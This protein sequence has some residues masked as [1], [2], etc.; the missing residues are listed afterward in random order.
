MA[1]F[2]YRK[3]EQT[4]KLIF[5]KAAAKLFPAGRVTLDHSLNNGIYGT[6]TKETPLSDEDIAALKKTMGEIVEKNYPI[7]LVTD[8]CEKLKMSADT[9]AREDVRKLLQNSG[10]I[11]VGCYEVHG[12]YDYL[13]T[14]VKP[15]NYTGDAPLFD[16]DRYNG[17]FILRYPITEE[18]KLLPRI[19]NPKMAK[20]FQETNEWERILGV[21]TIGYL[22]EK[23][24]NRDIGEL[25]RVNEALHHRNIAKIAGNIMEN[26]DIRLVT[27]AGPSS[28]G[29]TTFSKRLYVYLRACGVNPVII[30]LDDYYVGRDNIP[31]DENGK[32]DYETIDAL[33]LRLLNDNLRAL[34]DGEEVLVPQYNFRT[35]TREA[36]GKLLKLPKGGVII[37]EGIHGLNEKMSAAIE[38]RNKYKIYVS[39][40]TELNIDDHNRISTSD[41]RLIRRLVRDSFSRDIHVEETLSMW[42]SVRLGEQKHIFPFQ[43]EADVI[44]N[45][46][47]V[48]ELAVL[49]SF[50]L[51]ELIKVRVGTPS[52]QLAKRLLS[53][54]SCF[55][56]IGVAYVPD[57][58]LLR[59]FVGGSSFIEANYGKYN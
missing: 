35:G 29:K 54:V 18:G 47:L 53:L 13:Y 11:T 36:E 57:D 39:C 7:R 16:V 37:I 4:L 34:I 20:V 14:S 3:Y 30:S 51:R 44:F 42:H 32:K 23:I 31:T 12:Y 9:I 17:G 56:D 26:K 19:D 40:L 8:D 43:E 38:K 28:S 46:C 55:L 50:A 49:K 33:D 25:I 22:N 2:D 6:L 52:Y 5:L 10:A 58:S 45:S 27:I 21:P 24:L 59:E 48:Y 1:D 41:V 15:Y